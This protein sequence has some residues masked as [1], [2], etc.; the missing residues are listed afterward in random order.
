[1]AAFSLGLRMELS[2]GQIKG[3]CAA[4]STKAGSFETRMYSRGFFCE[5]DFFGMKSHRCNHS[6]FFYTNEAEFPCSLDA[7]FSKAISDSSP[8]VLIMT[9]EHRALFEKYLLLCNVD[10]RAMESARL[11]V[12]R[13]ASETL[14]RFMRGNV[15]N[16]TA[17]KDVIG[18]VVAHSQ[19]FHPGRQTWAYGEMVDVLNKRGEPAVALEL[20]HYWNELAKE[21]DFSLLCGYELTPQSR[22]SEEH[23][24]RAVCGSHTHVLTLPIQAHA[25]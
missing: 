23:F 18:A 13:D 17:F 12:Q 7:F 22:A 19:K 6:V 24:V 10:P 8:M 25:L 1:M 11:L 15:L 2:F 5:G 21:M 14:A 9:R 3:Q 20:E 16:W 4:I